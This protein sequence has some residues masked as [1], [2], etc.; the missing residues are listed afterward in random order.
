MHDLA[1]TRQDAPDLKFV[2]WAAIV[3]MGLIIVSIALG[4]ELTRTSMLVSP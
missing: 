2:I 3:S 1:K 4:S